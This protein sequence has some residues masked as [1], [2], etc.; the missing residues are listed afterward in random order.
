MIPFEFDYY[1]PATIQEATEAYC[2]LEAAG[3]EPVYYGG[4]SE[5]ISMARL[6]NLHFGSV[7]DIKAI[8]ECKVLE[9]DRDNQLV[10]GSAL[11][12]SEICES[13]QFPLL[14]K[15]A[16]RIADHTMQ[17]K[18]TLGGNLA[19]TILYRETVL[20]LLVADS[21]ITIAGKDGIRDFPIS[22]IF[23]K[24][25][26]LPKGSFVVRV[27]TE[28]GVVG[29]PYFHIK[30]TRN[31]KIDYPL[32]TVA[33]IKTSG[34]LRIAFSGLLP[35]PFRSIKVENIL[36]EFDDETVCAMEVVN[37]LSD[38]I[39]SDINGSSEY[40]KFELKNTIINVL[41]TMKDV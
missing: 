40:R 34:R 25:L 5:L 28:K 31:E 37:F 27:S 19:S 8:P 17:C 35:Y 10:L 7:I 26:N 33:G 41:E 4:G 3:K 22:R 16:G 24:R 6:G 29:S 18:I 38:K 11:T 36:N 14:E 30:K 32:I 13:K 21:R 20:P 2:Q 9:Y 23:D 15:T 1:K 12:L 39:L